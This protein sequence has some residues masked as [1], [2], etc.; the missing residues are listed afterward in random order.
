MT[1]SSSWVGCRVLPLTMQVTLDIPDTLAAQLT[2]AGKYPA[3]I[4]LEAWQDSAADGDV[5]EAVRQGR[6]NIAADHTV[7]LHEGFAQFRQKH[8]LGR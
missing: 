2:A 5:V 3:R 6:E 1:V 4:A 7:P 8:G